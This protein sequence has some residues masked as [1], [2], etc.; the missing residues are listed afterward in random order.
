M[1]EERLQSIGV[2]TT[3]NKI[4]LRGKS[5]PG[6]RDIHLR[7]DALSLTYD[8]YHKMLTTGY[9]YHVEIYYQR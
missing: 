3:H 6:R 8:G 1:S 2:R 7:A 4:L 9:R 5:S